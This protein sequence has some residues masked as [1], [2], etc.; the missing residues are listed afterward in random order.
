M[1]N[2]D[3][4]ENVCFLKGQIVLEKGVLHLRNDLQMNNG[5]EYWGL[6]WATNGWYHRMSG[7]WR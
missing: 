6:P 1:P 5:L 7:S 4:F 3:T 2:I